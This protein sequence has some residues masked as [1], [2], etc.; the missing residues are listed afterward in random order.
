MADDSD[1]Q[2]KLYGFKPK[3]FE[4]ANPGAGSASQDPNDV[5]AVLRENLER[6]NAAGLNDVVFATPRRS[7]RKR[8]YIFAMI[9][10]NMALAI[11]TVISPLF[12]GAG[13]VIY[14]VGITWVVWGVMDDY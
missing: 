10:G 13:L 5:R 14:N 11:C 2:R 9:A 7:K 12:G 3:E 6:A 4:R 1:P 8:D